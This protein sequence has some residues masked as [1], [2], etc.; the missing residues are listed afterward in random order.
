MYIVYIRKWEQKIHV[1]IDPILRLVWSLILH[2]YSSP[3]INL[4]TFH[5]K[6]YVKWK[7]LLDSSKIILRVHCKAK[8]LKLLALLTFTRFPKQWRIHYRTSCRHNKI[9]YFI[10][11]T[12]KVTKNNLL[13]LIWCVRFFLVTNW[14]YEHYCLIWIF[15]NKCEIY[16]QIRCLRMA[17][18][19]R[20]IN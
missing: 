15:M 12:N 20:R 18:E 9:M 1:D 11:K 19:T 10:K 6:G 13:L 3:R 16:T 8:Y 2:H 4:F 7:P 5:L 17:K 14:I